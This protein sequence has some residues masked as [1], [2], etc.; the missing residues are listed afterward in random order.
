MGD[1]FDLDDDDGPWITRTVDYDEEEKHA[2]VAVM[3]LQS[4]VPGEE[5]DEEGKK[6]EV[7]IRK[8]SEEEVGVQKNTRLRFCSSVMRQETNLRMGLKVRERER[9]DE[10]TR[11]RARE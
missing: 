2:P 6:Q 5:E 8:K 4:P 10:S 7:K 9:R 3:R 1:L 11:E